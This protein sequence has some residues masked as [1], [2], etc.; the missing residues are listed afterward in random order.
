M[1]QQTLFKTRAGALK[2]IHHYDGPGAISQGTNAG[3]FAP[4]PKPTGMDPV[5]REKRVHVQAHLYRMFLRK[6][7]TYTEYKDCIAFL[8][9]SLK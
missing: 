5:G 6:R 1:Y 9:E 4:G 3:L 7:I 2:P 8:M